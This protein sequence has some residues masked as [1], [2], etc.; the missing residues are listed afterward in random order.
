M[1]DIYLKNYWLLNLEYIN[2]FSRLKQYNI[3]LPLL[4]NFY[5]YLDEDIKNKMKD[6]NFYKQL[7][8][9]PIAETQ[10]QLEFEKIM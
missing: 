1:S 2:I 8:I 6:N 4:S 7:S 5:Q 9:E 3:P 10:L